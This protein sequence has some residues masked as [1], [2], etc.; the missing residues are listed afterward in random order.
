MLAIEGYRPLAHSR[1]V[2]Q[3]TILM[4]AFNLANH[5]WVAEICHFASIASGIAVV[6]WENEL[7]VAPYG[8]ATETLIGTPTLQPAK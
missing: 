5:R 7:D 4:T 3:S 8:G 2:I 6:C 1:R